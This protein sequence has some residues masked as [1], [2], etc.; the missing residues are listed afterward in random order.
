[1]A[2]ILNDLVKDVLAAPCFG[3]VSSVNNDGYPNI[4]RF[5]GF[6]YNEDNDSFTV[7]TFQNDTHRILDD[8][9]SG[10]PIAATAS[11]GENFQT[12]QFKGTFNRFYSPEPSELEIVSEC[13]KKQQ[14][15]LLM[16][17]ITEDVFSK[18]KF[19]PPTAIV[20]DVTEIFDQTPKVD[21]GKKIS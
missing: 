15:I 2:I 4:T 7:Y 8:L 13:N 14:K 17:G 20:I 21:A 18:W 1:M 3:F 5:F 11:N 16:M 12:S 19:T 10:D 9:N 6:N